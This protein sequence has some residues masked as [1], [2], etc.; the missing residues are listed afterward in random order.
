MKRDCTVR[1]ATPDDLD[2]ITAMWAHYIRGNRNNPVYRKI[3]PDSIEKRRELFER[4]V[5]GPDSTVFVVDR[6]DG[7][8]DG[9]IS[10]F[11]EKNVPYFNPPSF[12]RL[13]TPYVRPEARGRGHLRRL[14]DAAYRWAREMELTEVRLFT[15]A[16]EPQPNQL[17]EELGFEAFGIIRRKPI[18]WDYPPGDSP[19]GLEGGLPGRT[20][21]A[22]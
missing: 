10:C 11:V 16:L 14:L 12:G 17:A 15:S 2:E 4:H 5:R 8:L 19:G 3:P 20:P 22:D 21:G 18:S 1:K 9:M 6:P 13:Q 7:G